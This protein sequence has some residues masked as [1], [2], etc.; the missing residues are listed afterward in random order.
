M[1]G[2]RVSKSEHGEGP[3]VWRFSRLD[4]ALHL[5]VVVSFYALLVTGIPLLFAH[6]RWAQ[7]LIGLLGGVET[8]GVIHRLGATLTFAYLFI[9]LGAIFVGALRAPDRKSYFLGPNSM[10]PNA[11]DWRD[12]KQMFRY[13]RDRDQPP[14]FDR[15]SYMEK[16]E[17]WGVF[18]GV[19][20]MVLSGLLMWFP[21]FFA[22]FLPGWAF[23]IATILHGREALLALGVIFTIH[24]YNVNLRPEKFPIDVV[25]FTGR[26]TVEYMKEEHPLEYERLVREG[27]LESRIVPRTPDASYRRWVLFGFV[28]LSIGLLLVVFVVIAALF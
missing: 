4:R 6:S 15:F 18:W 2:H 13:F 7:S 17:Y 23:N 26:A 5:M 27:R 12:L 9:H 10:V 14:K 28:A 3:Y 16:F 1:T 20:I 25:I 8:A 22:Q 19:A 11:K 24:F 21:V